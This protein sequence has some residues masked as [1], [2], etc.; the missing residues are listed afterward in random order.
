[1]SDLMP[2]RSKPSNAPACVGRNLRTSIL[3]YIHIT[4]IQYNLTM[5]PANVSKSS[6]LKDRE[7]EMLAK[8]G[9]NVAK[10]EFRIRGLLKLMI[11]KHVH[12]A[13]SR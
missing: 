4:G 10:V 1:M 2:G 9:R 13:C 8:F 12:F 7:C 11:L 5:I 3:V 6:V